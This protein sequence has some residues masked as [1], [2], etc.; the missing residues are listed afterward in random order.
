MMLGCEERVMAGADV[1]FTNDQFSISD[2]PSEEW[3]HV[4]ML[5]KGYD[6]RG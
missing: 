4:V 6:F 3:A 1:C 2:R 5:G